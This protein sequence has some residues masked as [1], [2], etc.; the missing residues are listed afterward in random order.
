MPLRDLKCDDCAFIF[1]ALVRT[2]QEEK[3]VTCPSCEGTN[4]TRLLS[5]H[6]NYTISGDNSASVRPRKSRSNL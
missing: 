1:E 6:G 4:K 3:D 5:S 2:D